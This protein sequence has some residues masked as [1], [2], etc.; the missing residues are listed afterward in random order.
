MHGTFGWESDGITVSDVEDVVTMGET[1]TPVGGEVSIPA[2]RAELS[3]P[4]FGET[5]LRYVNVDEDAH[6]SCSPGCPVYNCMVVQ[7]QLARDGA[8]AEMV[9]GFEVLVSVTAGG[10]ISA[11]ELRPHT[12][13]SEASPG[14]LHASEW[15]DVTPREGAHEG[16]WPPDR[17][18]S[19]VLLMRS[20]AMRKVFDHWE[21]GVGLLGVSHLGIHCAGK[22]VA[23][24]TRNVVQVVFD[25]RLS[26][27]IS[28]LRDRR[29]YAGRFG[30]YFHG[31]CTSSDA[32]QVITGEYSKASHT[33]RDL[34]GNGVQ[35]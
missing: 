10:L 26:K 29:K 18:R 28:T 6:N 16:W 27:M 35:A 23:F 30:G 22:A 25:L 8:S 3:R 1:R 33:L 17:P 2:L 21:I 13:L 11:L 12:W 14:G 7:E 32:L 5:E 4:I 15:R 31:S 24:E 20:S 34:A 9:H 19:R